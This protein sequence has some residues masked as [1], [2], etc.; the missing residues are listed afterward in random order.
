MGSNKTCLSLGFTIWW[1]GKAVLTM[2]TPLSCCMMAV[3][4][5][6]TRFVE[7]RSQW[8][9]RDV[10]LPTLHLYIQAVWHS[11]KKV[12]LSLDSLAHQLGLGWIMLSS[13]GW[14][15]VISTW[16]VVAVL[17]ESHS[18][19]FPVLPTSSIHCQWV[20]SCSWLVSTCPLPSGLL[21]T[22]QVGHS[23]SDWPVFCLMWGLCCL[24]SFFNYTPQTF[25]PTSVMLLTGVL[26]WLC[27]CPVNVWNEEYRVLV[28]FCGM[29]WKK[30]PGAKYWW[31]SPCGSWEKTLKWWR[32]IDT[33]GL[34]STT[35]WTEQHGCI[36]EGNEQSLFPENAE[37]FHRVQQEMSS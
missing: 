13:L 12:R 20:R 8:C 24:I 7:K 22:W 21:I 36:H 37:I 34:T 31:D 3:S 2:Y 17:W 11:C 28:E 23:L 4:I 6:R 33:W 19:I 27:S 16:K 30:S 10:C 1:K 9:L 5:P 25:S 15:T 29:G 32:T 14:N 26:R 18:L 35:D